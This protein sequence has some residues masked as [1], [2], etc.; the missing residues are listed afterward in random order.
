MA[1]HL[2]LNAVVSRLPCATRPDAGVGAP[3]V[4]L[5]EVNLL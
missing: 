1:H 5:E 4:V 3:R 2:H